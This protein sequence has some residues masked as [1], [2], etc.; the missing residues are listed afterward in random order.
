MDWDP[1]GADGEKKFKLEST[2][3]FKDLLGIRRK[4]TDA[5]GLIIVFRF[6]VHYVAA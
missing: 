4:R 6:K 3:R 1:R 5:C 2:A